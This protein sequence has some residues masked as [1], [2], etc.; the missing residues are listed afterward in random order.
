[1]AIRKIRRW[2]AD[3]ALDRNVEV[4]GEDHMIM[5]Y[6][7]FLYDLPELCAKRHLDPDKLTFRELCA[8]VLTW[9]EKNPW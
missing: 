9:I 8:M 1:M 2:L 6:H 3:I 7:K 4:P 5:R